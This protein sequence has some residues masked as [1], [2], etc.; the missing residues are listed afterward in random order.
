MAASRDGLPNTTP[1]MP[2]HPYS[3]PFRLGL[4]GLPEAIDRLAPGFIYGLACDQQSVRLPLIAAALAA[5]AG[6][7]GHAVLVTSVE[8]AVLARKLRLSGLDVGEMIAEHELRIFLHQIETGR[9]LF[10]AGTQRLI[11]E[12]DSLGLPDGSLILA[13]GAD[14]A[15]CLADPGAAVQATRAWD[16][17]LAAHGHCLIAAFSPASDA[18]RDYVTLRTV[19]ESFGGFAVVRSGAEAVNLDLRHWFSAHGPVARRQFELRFD[20]RGQLHAESSRLPARALVPVEREALIV[21]KVA[22]TGLEAMERVCIADSLLDALDQARRIPAGTVVLHF[23]RA[24]QMAELA[25]AIVALRELGKPQLR[26]IVRECRARLRAAQTVALLRLGATSVLSA[27]LGDASVRLS[28]QALAGTLFNRAAEADV[29]Q[30]LAGIR[31][32]VRAVACSFDTMRQHTEAIL[33]ESAT[34]DLPVTLARFAPLSAQAAESIHAALRK[35][36]RDAVLSERNGTLWL[37]LQ[38]CSSLQIEPALSRLLGRRFD[39]L[40]SDWQ[41]WS[42]PGEIRAALEQAGQHETPHARRAVVR[43]IGLRRAAG[44][45]A[46]LALAV[47]GALAPEPAQAAD[48][49]DSAERFRQRYEAADYSAAAR[50]GAR[51]LVD[52]PSDHTLRLNVANSLAWSGRYDAAIEQYERLYGTDHDTAAR[53]G[54]ANI[55]RWRGMADVAAG[56]YE[57]ILRQ[58]PG[59]DEARQALV[60]AGRD[61]RAATTLR[62]G[63]ANTSRDFDRLETTVSHRWWTPGRVARLEVA[64]TGR[65]DEM[66]DARAHRQELAASAFLPGL[67][68]SPRVDVSWVNGD[69]DRWFGRVG[70]EIV[71]DR[72]GLR[73]GR[74]D[75]GRAALDLQALRDG[76]TAGTAGG[77][78]NIGTPLG[79]V[80]SRADGYSVSDGNRVYEADLRLLP[81]LQ[82]LPARL[83]WFVG[84]YWRKA[85]RNDPRYWSPAHAYT[86][87]NIGLQRGWYGERH[88]VFMSVQRGIA[89]SDEAR[90]NWSVSANGR[91]WVGPDTAIAAEA[92]WS[93]SPRPNPYRQRLFA[94]SVQQLW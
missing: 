43:P 80:R 82:P 89:L 4:S 90:H 32:P 15:F 45:L 3:S 9:D 46:A 10:A 29:A 92:S 73:Y 40:L 35:G 22:A 28:V 20:E 8:P 63:T 60:L 25:R 34:T 69:R 66:P 87:A 44:A 49:V 64:A 14:R 30:V 12:L 41:H 19:S 2:G 36:A 68:L 79:E 78:V 65:R 72:I 27:D 42:D 88:D 21:T 52:R 61:L 70:V 17:W 56:T 50:H 74:L 62:V 26:V 54:V 59:H 55:Q 6:R 81:A 93:D 23:D 58:H 24:A 94:V 18:P 31:A 76:L 84:A 39:A 51:A 57:A 11:A 71:R 16:E 83:Q 47:W 7:D 33:A 48:A 38:G 67:P 53:L 5:R 91:W 1:T 37:L 86:L 77:W 85:D 75:W 13:D